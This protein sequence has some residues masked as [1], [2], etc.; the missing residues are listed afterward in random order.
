MAKD[1]DYY[2]EKGSK[3]FCMIKRE[4][5]ISYDCYKEFCKNDYHKDCPIYKFYMKNKK[6]W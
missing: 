3:R 4:G 1:C 6:E 2:A 5:E